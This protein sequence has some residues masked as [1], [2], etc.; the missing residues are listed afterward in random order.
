MKWW[1]RAIAIQEETKKSTDL[2][3]V[4]EKFEGGHD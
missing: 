2:L 1:N 3:F 4:E